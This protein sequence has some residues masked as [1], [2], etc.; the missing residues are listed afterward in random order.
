MFQYV[1]FQYL[2]ILQLLNQQNYRVIY[3]L[4]YRLKEIFIVI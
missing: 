3:V 4:L 1:V 2:Y